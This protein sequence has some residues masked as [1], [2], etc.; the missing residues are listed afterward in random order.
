MART[1]RILSVLLSYPTEALRDS[2]GELREIL[3]AEGLLS[4]STMT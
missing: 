2:A 3:D 4:A 1:Y